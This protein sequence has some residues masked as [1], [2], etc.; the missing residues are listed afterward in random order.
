VELLHT[1]TLIHDDLPCMDDDDFRRGKPTAHKVFGEANAVL[2]GDAL[3]A[4]AFDLAARGPTALLVREL[5][6]AA[7]SRGVVGGQVA[8]LSAPAQP[9]AVA[10]AF[11]HLHKTADL[12]KASVRMGAIAG[13]SNDAELAALTEYAQSLGLAFQITDDLLDEAPQRRGARPDLSCLSVYPREEAQ[14]MAGALT[15]KAIMALR[16]CRRGPTEPLAAIAIF[17]QERKG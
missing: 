9:D 7:G 10:I 1:Y 16:A 14:R 8:D 11:I 13:G 4:L 5:A 2:A 17:V 15:E 6:A 12:F 3:Q